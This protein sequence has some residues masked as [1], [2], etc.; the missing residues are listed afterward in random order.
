MGEGVSALGETETWLPLQPRTPVP[1]PQML[2]F[3]SE[4]QI[5]APIPQFTW[6]LISTLGKHA[7]SV[8]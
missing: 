4:S 7:P 3:W 8:T 6:P 1:P 5:L 2:T